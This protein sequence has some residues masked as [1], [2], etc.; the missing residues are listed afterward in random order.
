MHF[1]TDPFKCTN[2]TDPSAKGFRLS[3]VVCETG[4]EEYK[5]AEGGWQVH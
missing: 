1:S 3:L 4:E 5:C 2:F